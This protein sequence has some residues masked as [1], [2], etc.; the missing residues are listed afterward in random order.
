M[1]VAIKSN[2]GEMEMMT[3]VHVFESAIVLAILD[4]FSQLKTIMP[5]LQTI[6]IRSD[7]AGC[8][9]CAQTLITAPQ[10]AKRHGL[11]IFRIDSSEP[12]GGKGACDRKAATKVAHG[13]ISEFWT[14]H[15]D[16]CTDKRSYGVFQGCARRN[17]EGVQSSQCPIHQEF[18]VGETEL[19]Q[20]P[21]L[22][23]GRD[24]NVE[25]LRHWPWKK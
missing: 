17:C 6:Y 7:N 8:Y 23:P 2:S 25:S 3:F 1:A 18:Q 20:Q 13:E 24:K 15:R 14:R 9:H 12:Q 16:C 21:L 11:Q 4:A 5:E 10:I 19:C 22:R